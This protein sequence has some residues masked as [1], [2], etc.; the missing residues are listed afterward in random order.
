MG[1]PRQSVL[2]YSAH[3]M[4]FLPS[5]VLFTLAAFSWLLVAGERASDRHR[6]GRRRGSEVLRYEHAPAR[7]L[8]PGFAALACA[9]ASVEWIRAQ[10]PS[11]WPAFAMGALGALF[12]ALVALRSYKAWVDYYPGRGLRIASWLGYEQV[13]FRD[14]ASMTHD[15]AATWVPG[16]ELACLVIRLHDGRCITL[17]ER[18]RGF[19]DLVARIAGDCPDGMVETNTEHDRSDQ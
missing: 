5:I 14:V 17:N 12:F 10:G 4:D 1:S 2:V 16:A 6:P 11:A 19:E 18:L 13:A 3:A 9:A 15:R 8:P 7:A